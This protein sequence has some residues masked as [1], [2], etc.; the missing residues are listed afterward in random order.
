MQ[1]RAR[2][3]KKADFFARFRFAYA[4]AANPRPTLARGENPPYPGSAISIA[5]LV[6]RTHPNAEATI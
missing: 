1:K 5:T 4:T 3:S 6:K 2:S